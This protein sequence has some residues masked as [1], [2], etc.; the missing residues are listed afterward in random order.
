MVSSHLVI[1]CIRGPVTHLVMQETIMS[2][3]RQDM[4]SIASETSKVLSKYLN[5]RT[6]GRYGSISPQVL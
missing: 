1:V 2:S 6:S 3:N 5:V 4:N